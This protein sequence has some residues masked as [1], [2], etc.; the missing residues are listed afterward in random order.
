MSAVMPPDPARPS[1]SRFA[2]R[3]GATGSLLCA[4]HCAS[5]PL[6]LAF[7][8]GAG[9]GFLFDESFE[10]GFTV[11][12]TLLAGFSLWTGYRRHRAFRALMFL[13]PG[14]AALWIGAFY[15]PVHH[16]VIA[17]AVAMT[18]GGTLIAVAHVLNLRLSHGHM[19]D[20]H[21]HH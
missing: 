6:L 11:F 19:H 17:H 13:L 3:F 8:P 16:N 4:L 2:D 12:A 15:G 18:M 9:I 7:L 5:L 21:C 20:A 10:V 14:L 1:L